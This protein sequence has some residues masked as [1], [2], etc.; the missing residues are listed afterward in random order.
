M[1]RLLEGKTALVF[2]VANDHSIA[3]GIAQAIHAHGARLAFSYAGQALERRIRPLAESV[4]ATFV[5][6][7]DVT[8]D[9]QIDA[10][11]ARAASDLGVVD[12]LVHAVAYAGRDE[13]SRP[14][15]QT[16]RAGF[17]SALDIS[18]Y[19]LTAL[20]R[21]VA[22]LMKNG[23]SIIAL[24]YYGSEK[25]MPN[26]NVMGVAKAALEASVR[27]LANDL[28][29]QGIRVNAISAGPVRTLSAAGVAGFKRIHREFAALAPLRRNITLEDLGQTA[30]W[31]ASGMSAAVTGEIV[32]V[33]S[34]YNILGALLPPEEGPADPGH[35]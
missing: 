10:L 6:P 8:R 32:F 22:P 23:G 9:D 18:A 33:D 29:P 2:G 17:L 5:E 3:W 31:L 35:R 28:G 26:Y 11:F 27:Y 19:S 4:G 7:C 12:I 14:F 1:S 25:V 24:T 20:A 21:G 16:S 13:L 30:V 34:G 15:V